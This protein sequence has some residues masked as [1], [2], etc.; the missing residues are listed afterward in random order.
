MLKFSTNLT[1][2]VVGL[3]ATQARV[4]PVS[5]LASS[6]EEMNTWAW[7]TF[8]QV[9]DLRDHSGLSG[10]SRI[11]CAALAGFLAKASVR[12]SLTPVLKTYDIRDANRKVIPDHPTEV[13]AKTG[14]LNFVST[15]AGYVSGPGGTPRPFVIMSADLDR[16]ATLTGDAIAR[17]PGGRTWAR[18]ARGLQQSL[19]KAWG[20]APSG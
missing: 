17:P 6:A 7:E 1:A 18:A 19:V 12:Q 10:Q 5:S 13:R 9:M 16:R 4:G 14:T 3:A 20:K 2:E 11:T 15:L 8:G